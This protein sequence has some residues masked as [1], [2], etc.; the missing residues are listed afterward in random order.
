MKKGIR[1]ILSFLMVVS[2]M[3]INMNVIYAINNEQS[4]Q[5]ERGIVDS[6]TCGE[7]STWIL[8]DDG[9]LVIDGTG[10]MEDYR[11]QYP[12][13]YAPWYKYQEN[14]YSVKIENGITHLGNLSFYNLY[15]LTSVEIPNSVTD[16]G[17]WTF[18]NAQQLKEVK[19]PNNL[20]KIKKSVFSFC[21]SLETVEI[22]EGVKSIGYS[23][24]LIVG[25]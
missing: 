8:Y 14:I 25:I 18:Y 13:K 6:G 22:P 7:K 16:L 2:M 5:E 9:E 1:V 19:L 20:E 10:E 12:Q 15:Q 23:V 4:N 21:G 11:E 24:F 17:E 3:G